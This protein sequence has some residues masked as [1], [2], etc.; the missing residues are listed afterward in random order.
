[1]KTTWQTWGAS[2][3][4]LFFIVIFLKGIVHAAVH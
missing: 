4:P 3:F 1:M 2:L